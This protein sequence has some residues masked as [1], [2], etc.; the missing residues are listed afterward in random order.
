MTRI[1]IW[2]DLRDVPVN[3]R[4]PYWKTAK[5]LGCER[6]LLGKDDPHL[7]RDDVDVVKVDGRNALRSGKKPIGKYIVL[8]NAKDQERAAQADGFVIIDAQN[9]AIIPLENLIAARKDRPGTLFAHATTVEDAL[10]F[11]DTLEVGV[12]GIAFAPENPESLEALDAA[13]RAKGAP[14]REAT[15]SAAGPFLVP[16]KVTHI[17]D[18]GT[19]DRVCIDTTSIFRPGEGLLVGSTARSFALVHAETVASEFVAKRP[20]RVNAGAVH[21]YLYSPEGKT[22]YLSELKAGTH[23]LA[24][25]PDGVHR[26][27]TVGRAK[28]E[29]RPHFLIKW[30]A[31]GQEGHAMLQNAETI[32]LVQPDGK[33]VSVTDLK[34]GDEILVHQEH[35]A[36]HFGM[37]VDEFLE[38]K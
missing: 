12:H 6:V 19:G 25:H 29:R 1:P 21:S 4:L 17:S 31:E 14:A 15:R 18:A 3:K 11:R 10:V 36:R 26:V 32:R 24:I 34:T 33:H 35:S 23:V 38:E 16:A 20:F 8:R 22:R 2:L 27:L 7:D 30:S 37:P 13:L 9:W 5:Q 28:I